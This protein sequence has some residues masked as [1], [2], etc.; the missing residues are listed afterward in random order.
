MEKNPTKKK[1]AAA[2]F[3]DQFER[4]VILDYIIRNTDR[5]SENWLI[6]AKDLDGLVPEVKIIAIDHGLAFPFK[7]PDQWRSYPYYWARLPQAKVPFSPRIRAEILPK[8]ESQ[9]SGNIICV[10]SEQSLVIAH[11]SLEVGRLKLLVLK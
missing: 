4:V 6:K 2:I 8:L 1:A 5:T 10:F 11:S 9:R 7:H 3:Q